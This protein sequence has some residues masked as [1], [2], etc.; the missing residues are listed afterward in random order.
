[1]LLFTPIVLIF[2]NGIMSLFMYP[3]FLSGYFFCKYKKNFFVKNEKLIGKVCLFIFLKCIFYMI[4]HI[5][6]MYP[7]FYHR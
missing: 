5:M 2:P 1:M 3:Y 4:R 6:F 7:G